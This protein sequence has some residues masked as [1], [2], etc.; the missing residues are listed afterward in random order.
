LPGL[1]VLTS[2]AHPCLPENPVSADYSIKK[3]N[4]S[5]IPLTEV[6]QDRGLWLLTAR[7]SESRTMQKDTVIRTEA[8]NHIWVTERH[9][10]SRTMTRGQITAVIEN[11][12]E[13]PASE[14]WFH[15]DSGEP[16]SLTVS[17]EG[18][19]THSSEYTETIDGKLINATIGDMSVS[20]S[21]MPGASLM[22]YYTPDSKDVSA[23][24]TIKAKGSDN[25]RMFYDEWKDTG[26]EIDDYSLSCSAGCDASGDRSCNITKTSA[27]YQA[28]WKK[29]ES[30]QRH[31]VDGTEFITTETSL[32]LTIKPYKEPDKPEVTLYGCSELSAEEQGEVFASGKPE[33]GKFRFWVE[34]GSLLEVQSDGESS[35]IIKGSAPGKGT[36]Y[37]EYTTIEGKT[38]TVSQPAS[39]VQIENYNNGQDVPQIPLFDIDGNKLTGKLTI[40]VSAQPSNIEEL[41][42]FVPADKSILSAVGLSGE[43]ELTGSREGK[44]TLQAKTNCGDDTGPAVSVEVVKCTDE[45]K[46]KL[47]EELKIATEAQQQAYKEIANIL[48]SE[49]FLKAADR[50]AE[51]T[52]NLAIKLGGAII[53]SLSGGKADAGVKTAAKI[54]GVGSNLLDFAKGLAAGENL[55]TVSNLSQ[56]I[57]ELGGSDNQQALASAIETMQAAHD[58]GTDLG[59]LI[60]TNMKL[61]EAVKWAEHWNK[62]I[63]D[64]VRRQKICRDSSEEPK[65][66]QQ[67][68]QEPKGTEQPPKDPVPPKSDP[69]DPPPPPTD[70][71][72]PVE[73][74][75]G[76][77][78]PAEDPAGNDPGDTEVP[79]VPPKTEPTQINLPYL[80]AEDCGCKSS[81]GLT[82]NESGLSELESGF[83]NLGK[84]VEDFSNG[85]LT[86]YVTTLKGWK[87]VSETLDNAI[88]AGPEE[89]KKVA[90]EAAPRI[91]VLLG[92]T[93]SF[94]E[95][96]RAFYD[97]FKACPE[98]AASGVGLMKSAMNVTVDSIKT[99]Y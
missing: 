77:E 81:K 39:C 98:S 2:F 56:M 76:D 70:P 96:G 33:G 7:I 42:D 34:P 1:F 62:Y 16:V 20:G 63:Q 73:E 46:A 91:E 38:N 53:G 83:S 86:D 82:P 71:V 87:E 28:T 97:N 74:P 25:G 80:P 49:D 3:E 19:H 65:G 24:I 5:A 78:P 47:A 13:D 50:I 29:S 43:V 61:K 41:V 58:F 4:N 54:Y 88:K 31:T 9:V 92:N 94:D 72:P 23:G 66:S 26:G 18:S 17:G 93:K 68:P 90:G 45:T 14:F 6:N 35:A 51:S 75:S 89:L 8:G 55:G 12:A 21:A 67:P 84:C 99:K 37:V 48:G 79:P 69:V 10:T 64:V 40:P 85:P 15:T 95:T 36:L 22:F 11:Q 30:R 59:S 52:G 44:T 27:G 32:D 60:A 57:V